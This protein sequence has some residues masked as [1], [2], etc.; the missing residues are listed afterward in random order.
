[1][2]LV[3]NKFRNFFTV[4]VIEKTFRDF[5]GKFEKTFLPKKKGHGGTEQFFQGNLT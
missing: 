3:V 2:K 1:M 4:N 5:F